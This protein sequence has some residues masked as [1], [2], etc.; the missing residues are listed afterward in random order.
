M[1][2]G[3]QH[4]SRSNRCAT[5]APSTCQLAIEARRTGYETDM[6][7]A[8]GPGHDEL[9]T[10]YRDTGQPVIIGGSMET[11]SYPT[12]GH[13]SRLRNF[14]QHCAR[15]RP[16]DEP[17]QGAQT[18]AR[19]TTSARSRSARHLR[20]QHLMA[21]LAEEAGGAYKDIDEVIAATELAGISKPVARFSPIGNV[22]G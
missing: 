3:P 5:E 8:F 12:R 10:R 1:A 17:H 18:M 4:G 14:L 6:T 20:P 2:I 19:Q 11:G 13:N 21:G 7:R 15:E 16:H 9:P 22:K